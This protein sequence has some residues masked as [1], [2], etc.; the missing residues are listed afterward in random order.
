MPPSDFRHT[1]SCWRYVAFPALV[2]EGA[3][4]FDSSPRILQQLSGWGLQ[5]PWLPHISQG[6]YGPSAISLPSQH[7]LFAICFS[8]S[9][10]IFGLQT[11]YK[12][13]FHWLF[14]LFLRRLA[15]CSTWAQGELGSAATYLAAIFVGGQFKQ[16]DDRKRGCHLYVLVNLNF[17]IIITG[18]GGV[19]KT[20]KFQP[21][22]REPQ[23]L[24]C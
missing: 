18:L 9:S 7:N 8:M 23:K 4:W 14:T 1:G 17:G 16:Q 10:T 3:G 22:D 6:P 11:S 24:T 2:G 12:L 20:W 13:G 21:G 19:C 5:Q 15:R